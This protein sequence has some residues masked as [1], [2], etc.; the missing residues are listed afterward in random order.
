LG[1]ELIGGEVTDGG[2]LALL[3]VIAI[4]VFNPDY[5]IGRGEREGR[6]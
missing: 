2:V 3:V 5:A 1:F 4:D 6:Q